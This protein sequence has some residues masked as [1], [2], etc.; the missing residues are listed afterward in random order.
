MQAF[1]IV[2]ATLVLYPTPGTFL[3]LFR[4]QPHPNKARVSLNSIAD[5]QL[6]ILFNTS[7]KDFKGNFVKVVPLEAMRQSFNFPDGQPKFPFYWTDNPK[8]VIS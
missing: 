3:H 8:R 6:F 7:Y 5:Q 4:M 1:S 2:C